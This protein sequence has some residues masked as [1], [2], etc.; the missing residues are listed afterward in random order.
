M[1]SPFRF[2]EIFE[3][4]Q[5]SLPGLAWG[6]RSR[7]AWSRFDVSPR[8][9]AYAIGKLQKNSGHKRQEE[10]LHHHAIIGP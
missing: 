4:I 5:R 10:R 6:L 3:R 8:I 2:A 9:R 1:R 7:P